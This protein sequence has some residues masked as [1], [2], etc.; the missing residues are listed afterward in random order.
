MN[1]LRGIEVYAKVIS[2]L[3][4]PSFL[5]A[6]IA[7][8]LV[9]QLLH[10]WAVWLCFL[11]LPVIFSLIY[12]N[13][14]QMPKTHQWVIPKEFR[15]FPL[16]FALLGTMIFYVFFCNE[17]PVF[18]KMISLSSL[19]LTALALPVTYYWKISLHMMGMGAFSIFMILY[20]QYH[21]LSVLLT[22]LF[23]QQVAWARMYLK[24]HD[25]WQ[26]LAGYTLGIICFLFAYYVYF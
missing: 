8:F 10:Q 5:Q 6:L 12:L 20:F 1:I 24:S 11:I 2:I 7:S 26:I 13:I 14:A 25:I 17:E 18:V 3:F 9:T 21:W 16:S 22:I 4:Y 15:I 19:L 23:S